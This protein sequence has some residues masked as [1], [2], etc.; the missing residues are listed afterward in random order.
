[1]IVPD[2]NTP[3]GTAVIALRQ[4]LTELEERAG[5][6]PG[7]DV[8]DILECGLT[9]RCWLRSLHMAAFVRPFGQQLMILRLMVV[10]GK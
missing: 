6:W 1:M 10:H 2:P 5:D 4:K 3:V 9:A 8:V 7:A